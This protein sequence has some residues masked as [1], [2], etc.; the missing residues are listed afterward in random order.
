[1]I[2]NLR[3][4]NCPI[5]D[6]QLEKVFTYPL[7]QA[8]PVQWSVFNETAYLDNYDIKVAQNL[9]VGK[10]LSFINEDQKSSFGIK[11]FS[12]ITESGRKLESGTMIYTKEK[13]RPIIFGKSDM[14]EYMRINNNG[15]LLIGKTTQKNTDYKLDVNGKIRANEI[16]V[17]MDGAD[18]VFD[19]D[20]K[21]RS[22]SDL[23]IFIA[24][25]KHLPDIVPAKE[26]QTNG[27]NIGKFNTKLLQKI[28][29]LT[30]YLI[31]QD[32]EINQLKKQNKEL[33]TRM[34]KLE[35]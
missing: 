28:E 35:N 17:N 7:K 16:R 5:T 14:T 32:D 21:L 34:K 20:Y 1:M 10:E 29:E 12:K 2:N 4:Y 19:H 27:Q 15:N 24:K 33:I 13:N 6:K 22:L 26:M 31:K 11:S 30:I 18:F 23:K 9:I 3:V 8:T 25:N